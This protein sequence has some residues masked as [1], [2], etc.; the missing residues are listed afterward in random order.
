MN[1]SSESGLCATLISRTWAIGLLLL[2]TPPT[3]LLAA[4]RQVYLVVAAD[5]R[6]QS[7]GRHDLDDFCKDKP[8]AAEH[9]RALPRVREGEKPTDAGEEQHEISRDGGYEIAQESTRC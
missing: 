2:I 6:C 8:V 3:H 9:K 5:A 4:K 1:A 7:R